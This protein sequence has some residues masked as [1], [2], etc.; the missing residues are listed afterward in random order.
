MTIRTYLLNRFQY[1]NIYIY[2]LYLNM[3]ESNLIVFRTFENNFSGTA[4][5]HINSPFRCELVGEEA[6]EEDLAVLQVS[7]R[8]AFTH[9]HSELKHTLENATVS[10][11]NQQRLLSPTS[12]EH[13]FILV[14]LF[15]G[16]SFLA[17]HTK[18]EMLEH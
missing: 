5:T 3:V 9:W 7:G 2:F 8:D 11:S 10:S 4:G 14:I 17:V 16:A 15:F 12:N 18:L 13:K 6:D 1:L